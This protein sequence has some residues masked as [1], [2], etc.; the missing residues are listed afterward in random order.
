LDYT[1]EQPRTVRQHHAFVYI[2]RR[3]EQ[4]AL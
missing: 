4:R 3:M 1:A 2:G